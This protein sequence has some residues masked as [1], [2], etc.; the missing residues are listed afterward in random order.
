MALCDVA[1]P[2]G[3]DETLMRELRHSNLQPHRLLSFGAWNTAGNTIGSTIAHGTL[4]LIALQDKGAFDLAQLLADISPMRYLELLNS[5]IDSER[6]HVE[7]LFGRFVDD[8]LYQSRIRPEV[9]ERVVRLLEASVFDLVNSYRQTERW[10]PG[11]RLRPAT[12]DRSLPTGDGADSHETFEPCV[13]LEET[14]GCRGGAVRVDLDSARSGLFPAGSRPPLR[15]P[16]AAN[17]RRRS[18]RLM[19]MSDIRLGTMAR[20]QTCWSPAPSFH[21]SG[22]RR[23]PT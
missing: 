17:R 4:R 22:D 6:A 19:L 20:A 21:Q 12:V 14:C 13:A 8:W 9:T 10:W 7:F 3:A 15:E 18:R 16:F 5:L 1:F 23:W 11:S 2:N